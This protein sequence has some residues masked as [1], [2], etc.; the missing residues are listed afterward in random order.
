V[1]EVVKLAKLLGLDG[2][3]IT[4]HNTI[5]GAVEAMSFRDESMIVIP[6][7]EIN[8]KK[9]HLIALGVE[10][11]IKPHRDLDETIDDIR[12]KGGMVVIPH[13]F[14]LF[15]HSIPV[16]EI[17][18]LKPDAVEILNSSYIP[19][20]ILTY[21]AKKLVEKLTVAKIAGSDSHIPQSVGNA[22]TLVKANSHDM[23]EVLKAVKRGATEVQ[24]RPTSIMDRLLTW[25]LRFKRSFSFCK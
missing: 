6:G 18:N 21:R 2:I 14:S 3:A 7:V 9:G 23:W 12:A 1:K 5:T 4:D 24:G 15:S 8:T 13:P 20:S 19:F 22:Y 17:T 11:C 10:E 25:T 16:G